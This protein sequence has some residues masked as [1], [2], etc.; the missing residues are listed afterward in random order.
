[1]TSASDPM[2]AVRNYTDAFNRGDAKGQAA[3]C[4]DPMQILDGIPRM[5]GKG[6]QLPKIGGETY[7]PKVSTWALRVTTSR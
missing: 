3:A 6:E 1:M 2:T 4:A 7:S 5:Y